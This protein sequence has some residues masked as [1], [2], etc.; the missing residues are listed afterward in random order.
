MY[1]YKKSNW[2]EK[3]F[4]EKNDHIFSYGGDARNALVRMPENNRWITNG[5]ILQDNISIVNYFG[6]RFSGKAILLR[7]NGNFEIV[8]IKFSKDTGIRNNSFFSELPM[9]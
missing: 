8:T 7:N 5:N 1:K 4:E 2:W 6:N 3:L 9:S